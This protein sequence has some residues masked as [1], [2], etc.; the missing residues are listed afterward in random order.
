M[1]AASSVPKTSSFPDHPGLGSSVF[2]FFAL[3]YAL[4]WSCWIPVV[5]VPNFPRA[6][7]YAL[8]L[9]GAFAP[10]IVALLLTWRADGKG[11]VMALLSH[12]FQWQVGMRWYVFAIAYIVVV[13]LAAALIY[14]LAFGAWPRFGSELPVVMLVAT[15][16]ST[17]FQSGEEIGWRG[18]AL[19]RLA[20]V[21]GYARASLLL[22][23]VWTCW[24]LPQ[25]FFVSA[26]TYKQSFP[27]WSLQVVAFS[28]A[29][30][31]VY[32]GTKG[33][34]LLTMLMHAAVNNLKD[35]VPSAATDA[36]NAFS[37]HASPVMYLTALVLWIAAICF[38]FH[39]RKANAAI[40]S[41]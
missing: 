15:L 29:L 6:I 31:W 12:L 1:V 3:T 26:D 32:V 41:L 16:I 19:P 39:L 27:I 22:G 4:T 37:L 33:S 30:A 23:V 34:L 20:Q 18:Y 25:F 5:L 8:W 2:R 17:P 36:T 14:R 40:N 38:L 13:K 11:G 24:H 7:G 21:M 10:S 9:V 35:T 28:V